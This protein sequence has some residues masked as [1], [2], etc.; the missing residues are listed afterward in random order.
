MPTETRQVLGGRDSIL[1]AACCVLLG[2]TI[3]YPAVRLL[4]EAARGWELQALYAKSGLAALR[5]TIFISCLSVFTSAV[6]GSAL[7]LLLTRYAF[8]GRGLLA[9]LAY[10]PFTLPP[11]VGTVSFYYIIG[12]DGFVPRFLEQSF[13]L[14]NA[15]LQGPAAILLIH[16]YSFYVFF[17]AMVSSAIDTLDRSQMEAARTLGASPFRAFRE[18]T[19]PMLMPALR[20]AALLTFMSSGASFS[21]PLIFGND[22]PMLSVRIYEEQSA[23][24]SGAAMTL[25]VVLAAVSLL[26]VLVF[27]ARRA[28]GGVASKGVRTPL[29]SQRARLAA[30]VLAGIFALI[31]LTPHL[32]ILWLSFVNHREWYTEV[33]PTVFT[34]D[35]YLSILRDPASFGPIR[36]SVW[37][38]ALAASATLAV[39]LPCA[40]LVARKRPGG[41]WL[42]VLVMIPWAL[43]GTV[44]AIN[45]IVAFNESWAP[46][47]GTVWILPL[48]YFVRNVPLL[49]RMAAAAIEPFDA[50]LIEAGRSLGASPAYCF[51]HIVTPLLTPAI[52]A[53]TALVFATCLG[54]FVASVL[55]WVPANIPIAVQIN[56]AWRGSGIGTAFAY[57]VL[58]M[59]LVAATYLISR[60]FASRIL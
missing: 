41:R 33:F 15:F 54:E 49:T 37:M 53:G 22:Y 50:T 9:G 30:G 52:A 3:A 51:R 20:G 24:N 26:G 8:P 34:L 48:A 1:L 56:G 45:L 5:N 35:N 46:L 47:A 17:Y 13:G 39:A 28:A 29:R 21:A 10:L 40:Y 60:R 32:T 7:A 14:E 11:L 42:N 19:L 58:L 23:H 16:T 55:L 36:N 59:A 2:L 44:I 38:S 31:L 25:T 43:P 18:V 27:R 4:W 12:R 57:S 6:L